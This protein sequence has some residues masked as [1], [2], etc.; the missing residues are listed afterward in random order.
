MASIRKP[1]TTALMLLGIAALA[2]CRDGETPPTMPAPPSALIVGLDTPQTDDGA[3]VFTLHGPDLSDLQPA[4]GAYLTYTRA[5]GQD[6]RVVMVGDLAAGS[7]LT[8]KIGA[9]HQLAEYSAVV[10]QVAMRSDTLR[11]DLSRYRLTITPGQ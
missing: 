11:P 10:E 7:L 4:S 9:G 6:V 8:A 1:M 3:V 5:I 2:G